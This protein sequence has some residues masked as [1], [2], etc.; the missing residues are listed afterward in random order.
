[1][2]KIIAILLA[3]AMVIMM[4][5]AIVQAEA[6]ETVDTETDEAAQEEKTASEIEGFYILNYSQAEDKINLTMLSE[7]DLRAASEQADTVIY[8]FR[9]DGSAVIYD[10]G[11]V[12]EGTYQYGDG[13]LEIEAGDESLS[14]DYEFV[15]SLLIIR[16]GEESSILYWFQMEDTNYITIDDY[17][18][19]KLDM[20]ALTLTDEDVDTYVNSVLQGQTVSEEVR[21][22][23]AET[24]DIITISF[25]GVLEGEEEPFEG[26]SADGLTFQLGSGALV[27]DFEDQLTGQEIGSTL[28]VVITFPE[29]YNG[30]PDLIGKTATFDTTILFKTLLTVPELTDEWVQEFTKTY[31]PE[32]L[33]TVEE[34]REYCRSFEEESILHSA[35][36][37]ELVN[38]STITGYNGTV[39]QMLLNYAS[40]NLSSLAEYYGYDMTTYAAKMGF[41]SVN[42]YVQQEASSYI[43]SAMVVNKILVDLGIYYSNEELE[44]A[45]AEY[46]RSGFG[47]TLTVEEYKTQVGTLG[48][49][50]YTNMIFKYD[51]AMKALEDRIT[52]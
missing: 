30:N 51:L 16:S 29:D 5:A 43:T 34:F 9:D 38:R 45:L 32:Q 49:W 20:D 8:Q 39:A 19:I 46:V 4:G 7:S 1:M 31:L 6:E 48:I 33:N 2:K 3:A 40:L 42:D 22:G 14:Y 26:G 37:N 36:F 24:G 35:I 11:E 41:E 15:D 21:E 47:D 27:A 25:T 12:K 52:Q 50:A 28:D 17:S 13:T 44:D 23:T 10:R 18:E